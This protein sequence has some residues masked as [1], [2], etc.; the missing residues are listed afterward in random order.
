MSTEAKSRTIAVVGT[1]Q[2]G[3]SIAQSCAMAGHDAVVLA[4]SRASIERARARV[5]S[6][7]QAM[8]PYG[9]VRQEDLPSLLSRISYREDS[10]AAVAD[11][12]LIIEC[13]TEDLP[14][15]QQLFA[16]LECACSPDTILLSTTSGLRCTDIAA[17]MKRPERAIVGHYW[18]PP[19]LLPLVE[20]S[21]GEKTSPLVVETVIAFLRTTGHTP[22]VCRKELLGF[23]ANRLQQA[24]QREAL[25][26]VEQGIA[27]PQEVDDAVKTGFGART[28]VLGVFE[29]MDL[30]G[31]DLIEYMHNYILGDLDAQ[32]H[33]NAVLTELVQRG[34]LGAKTGKGFYDW[35]RKSAADVLRERDTLLLELAAK[36]MKQGRLAD[37]D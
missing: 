36:R 22:V 25:A 27:T 18:N 7:L 13:V 12:G 35:S 1:G 34:D 10:F 14:L 19:H 30:V 17:R 20:I 9:L 5:Q 8:L 2:M 15:K 28:P 11:A 16:A 4:R 29:H 24:L 33:A 6:N 37:K 31:L 23:V 32:Q 21:P 3:P 26:I